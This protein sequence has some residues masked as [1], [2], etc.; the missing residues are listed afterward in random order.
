[1]SEKPKKGTI[2]FKAV[3]KF[4]KDC[5]K[6]GANKVKLDTL[7]FEFSG[8]NLA[9]TRPASKVSKK[10]IAETTEQTEIQ[11]QFDLAKAE[12][13]NLHVADPVAFESAMIDQE[14]E[15]DKSAGLELEETRHIGASPAL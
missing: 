8:E 2:S 13:A 11:E 14:I 1:M 4:M 12:L 9:Q 7:E 5:K 3:L 10:K 15:D 6:I